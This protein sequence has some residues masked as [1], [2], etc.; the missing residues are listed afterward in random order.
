MVWTAAFV[1]IKFSF[2]KSDLRKKGA[3]IGPV[4]PIISEKRPTIT[5][6]KKKPQ[7]GMLSEGRLL[8]LKTE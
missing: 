7:F 4:A 6:K 2:F 3:M 5:P 8:G 1:A